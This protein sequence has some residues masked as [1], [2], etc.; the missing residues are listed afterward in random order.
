M[1]RNMEVEDISSTVLAR[2]IGLVQLED[3]DAIA[4]LLKDEE[5]LGQVQE[6]S[7]DLAYFLMS[8]IG[9]K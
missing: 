4:P 9:R 3:Y 1:A 2:V 5:Q 6:D 8:T 7:E